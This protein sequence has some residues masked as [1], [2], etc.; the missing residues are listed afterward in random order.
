MSA[1]PADQVRAFWLRYRH[2]L[3]LLA[4]L[5]GGLACHPFAPA[6]AWLTPL[7][8]A[9]GFI[10]WKLA[11]LDRRAQAWILACVGI[12]LAL[13]GITLLVFGYNAPVSSDPREY[14]V[15]ATAVMEAWRSGNYPALS[16]KGS[17]PHLGSLH[18]GYERA[19][20]SV[21]LATGPR[22]AAGIAL[23]VACVAV[24]P[25]LAF[26]ASLFL[27]CAPQGE[28]ENAWDAR[29][30]RASALLAALYPGFVFWMTWLVKDT[31][32]VAV[33]A[34]CL[35]FLFD[36]MRT[37]SLLAWA[38]FLLVSGFLVIVRAYAGLSLYLGVTVYVFARMPRRAVLWG[39]AYALL[40]LFVAGYTLSGT[41][42]FGQLWASLLALIPGDMV[43]V[44]ESLR[45]FAGGLPRSFLGPYGWVKARGDNLYY[46]LYPGMW[47]LYL[48]VYPLAL[49]GLAE[50]VRRNHIPTT[51]PL[52]VVFTGVLI[53]LMTY[54]GE[55][56][57][58]R[59]YLEFVYIL[60]AGTGVSARGRRRWFVACWAGL[61]LFA[62]VQLIS[63]SLR[64]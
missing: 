14:M 64:S 1:Q 50:A 38:G 26:L 39:A 61:F 43:T 37:R 41:R 44:P 12:S 62:A 30:A 35:V 27:F 53:F 4:V 13:Q 29:P 45:A 5:A 20:A 10:G 2:E 24:L 52:V 34:A 19:L 21:F 28:T 23:N 7:V 32:L 9:A 46:G 25:A 33:F 31:L 49:A 56:Q 15:K 17:L 11:R 63:L 22:P 47:F 48:L 51:I 57:R 18:T 36:A 3:P 40:A 55:A 60:Y 6:I 16:L 59:L 54:G 42:L 58:Q 8:F